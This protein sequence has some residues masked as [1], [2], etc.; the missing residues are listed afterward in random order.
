MFFALGLVVLPL[1]GR[2]EILGRYYDPQYTQD[3]IASCALPSDSI[4][5]FSKGKVDFH[6]LSCRIRK[7]DRWPNGQDQYDYFVNCEDGKKYRLIIEQ[8]KDSV[9]IQWAEVRRSSTAGAIYRKCPA[10]ITEQSSQ[11]TALPAKIGQCVETQ[12]VKISDRFGK[13]VQ[14]S[15][16]DWSGTAVRFSNGGYQVSY[17]K[18]TSIIRSKVGD[19]VKMCL[20][21]VPKDCPKGDERGKLYN[22]QN[23]RTGEA[24][25]LP[26]SQH[27][28]GGA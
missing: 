3:P 6:E 14:S 22:T 1:E 19:T 17:D 18:E 20:R 5:S 13:D 28:C 11:N 27:R 24:W 21:A 23:S 12:I 9:W 8:T 25:T 16:S 10:Q 2:T 26:D 7:I 15:S 4:V